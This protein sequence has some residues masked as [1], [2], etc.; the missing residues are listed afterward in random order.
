MCNTCLLLL[1]ILLCIDGGAYPICF[2]RF[3]Y[4]WLLGK[5]YLFICLG[6]S[7]LPNAKLS[8]SHN[9][10]AVFTVADAYEVLTITQWP[11]LNIE[12]MFNARSVPAC[13]GNRMHVKWLKC[14]TVHFCCV[15]VK[16]KQSHIHLVQPPSRS[17]LQSLIFWLPIFVT[18]LWTGS[19]KEN[20]ASLVIP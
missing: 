19:A 14:T 17:C 15:M 11:L 8:Q 3:L 10:S 16:E 6:I 18:E 9:Y 20:K 4:H 12:C 5:K 1:K 7:R 13:T 2:L